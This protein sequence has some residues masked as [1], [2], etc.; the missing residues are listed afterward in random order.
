MDGWTE[1]DGV[2]LGESTGYSML[3]SLEGE[4]ERMVFVVEGWE[5]GIIY[6]AM[7]ALEGGREWRG[8]C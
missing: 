7:L 1:G 8:R 2:F 3:Y 5:R 4:G 6:W